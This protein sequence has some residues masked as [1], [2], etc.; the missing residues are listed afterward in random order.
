[1]DQTEKETFA[2]I[3][4]RSESATEAAKALGLAHPGIASMRA[5]YLR[6]Q[7]CGGSFRLGK[8]RV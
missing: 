1:M 8:R 5:C 7:G 4:N 3:W 6:K 2:L